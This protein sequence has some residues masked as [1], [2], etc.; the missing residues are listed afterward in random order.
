[1]TDI[2]D[3][4]LILVRDPDAWNRSWENIGKP[5]M[6]VSSDFRWYVGSRGFIHLYAA[7]TRAYETAKVALAHIFGMTNV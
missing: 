1:M 3:D 7:N 5:M 4:K 6:G 2:V